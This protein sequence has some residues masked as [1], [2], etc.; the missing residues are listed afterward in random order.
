MVLRPDTRGIA[1]LHAVVPVA[2][3]LPPVLFCQVTRVTPTLSLA[4]P[5][6]VILPS[7]EVT[8]VVVHKTG[9]MPEIKTKLDKPEID[10]LLA[11]LARQAVRERATR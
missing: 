10:N 6:T 4:V 9:W 8:E 2:V 1:A 5:L 11:F 3:P 7:E